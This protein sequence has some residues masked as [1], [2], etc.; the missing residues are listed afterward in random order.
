MVG[1]AN[2]RTIWHKSAFYSTL[3]AT[4]IFYLLLNFSFTVSAAP[5]I[6]ETVEALPSS[7]NDGN[8]LRMRK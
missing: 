1:N 7:S 6:I 2:S 3:M 4:A 5:T 8:T